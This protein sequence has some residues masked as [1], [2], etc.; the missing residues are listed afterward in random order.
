[1]KRSMNTLV[2]AVML[3]A[4]SCNVI[5]QGTRSPPPSYSHRYHGGGGNYHH[6]DWVGALLFL[7]L[8]ATLMNSAEPPPPAN[9]YVLPPVTEPRPRQS[10]PVGVWYY[11]ASMGQYYPYVRSCPEPWETVPAVPPQ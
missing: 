2:V 7:G 6:G 3:A 4:L 11:C 10:A 1:M 5:A 9:T 8:L